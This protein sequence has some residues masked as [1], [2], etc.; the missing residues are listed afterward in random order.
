MFIAHDQ[1]HAE[2]QNRE[3]PASHSMGRSALPPDVRR[4]LCPATAARLFP[5]CARGKGLALRTYCAK[6]PTK[7]IAQ[8]CKRQLYGGA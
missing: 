5:G 2:Y 1:R 3:R 8:K 4:W 7:G 6:G